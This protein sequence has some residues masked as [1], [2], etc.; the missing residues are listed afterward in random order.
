LTRATLFLRYDAAATLDAQRSG[1]AMR[2]A[3]ML[4]R[5]IMRLYACAC[6][7]LMRYAPDAAY[8]RVDYV[9]I[10]HASYVDVI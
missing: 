9:A 4:A 1:Y 5:T 6:A 7:L 10:R 2:Y 8:R 3:A